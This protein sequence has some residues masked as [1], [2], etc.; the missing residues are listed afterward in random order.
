MSSNRRD[1]FLRFSLGHYHFAKRTIETFDDPSDT[2]FIAGHVRWAILLY[3]AYYSESDV[4]MT[5]RHY[6][7]QQEHL[8]SAERELE[9]YADAI[10]VWDPRYWSDVDRNSLLRVIELYEQIVGVNNA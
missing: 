1:D 5:L 8:E 2:A 6:L 4:I 10:E 3:Y 7:N 9:K